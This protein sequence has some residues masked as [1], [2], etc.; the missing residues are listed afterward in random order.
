MGNDKGNWSHNWNRSNRS[1][2]GKELRG[3]SFDP[4][5]G[6]RGRGRGGRGPGGWDKRALIDSRSR[7]MRRGR[8]GMQTQ[9]NS[10]TYQHRRSTSNEG[11]VVCCTCGSVQPAYRCPNCLLKYCSVPCYKTHKIEGNQCVMADKKGGSQ[12]KRDTDG[13]LKRLAVTKK[14]GTWELSDRTETERKTYLYPTK[15]TVLPEGLQALT[16]EPSRSKLLEILASPRLKDQILKLD[17]SPDPRSML[18]ALADDKEFST[19]RSFIVEK[20]TPYLHK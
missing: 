2:D 6:G 5:R 19:F 12:N 13:I 10:D 4:R 3:P 1:E 20:L 7:R 18:N 17:A 8:G 14:K 11:G 9:R 15:D 16:E